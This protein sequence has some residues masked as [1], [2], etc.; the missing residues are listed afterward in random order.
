[1]IRIE[2]D[3]KNIKQRFLDGCVNIVEVG[4][5]IERVECSP[6][7]HVVFQTILAPIPEV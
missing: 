6:A 2:L 4:E 5:A 7:D 1:M 3:K